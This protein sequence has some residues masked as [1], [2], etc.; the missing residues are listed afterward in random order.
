M[1]DVDVVRT[2][3][4]VGTLPRRRIYVSAVVGGEGDYPR[5]PIESGKN[6][7]FKLIYEVDDV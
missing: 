5:T 1:A 2:I 7:F 3:S 6:S 4:S